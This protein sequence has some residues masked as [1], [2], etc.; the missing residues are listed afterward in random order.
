M[1]SDPRQRAKRLTI[2]AGLLSQDHARVLAGRAPGEYEYIQ[3][4]YL[5]ELLFFNDALATAVLSWADENKLGFDETAPHIE[6]GTF[7]FPLRVSQAAEAAK[8]PS[9]QA[10]QRLLALVPN[11]KELLVYIESTRANTSGSE[12][13]VAEAATSTVTS[14]VKL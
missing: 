14:K 13:K 11:A 5:A 6:T 8:E 1:K 7:S 9:V 4:I 3:P 2:L 12:L 10:S